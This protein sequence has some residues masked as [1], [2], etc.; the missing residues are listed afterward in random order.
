MIRKLEKHKKNCTR[1][2]KRKIKRDDETN[3]K[4]ENQYSNS[5]N[6]TIQW[7]SC[8]LRFATFRGLAAT[9]T[10]K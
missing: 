4:L 5:T 3:E 6:C 7:E 2:R 8:S 1:I 10:E 9:G